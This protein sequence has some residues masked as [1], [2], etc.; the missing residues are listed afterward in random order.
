MFVDDHS[1]ISSFLIGSLCTYIHAI[2]TKWYLRMFVKWSWTLI[3]F[4]TQFFTYI[5][6][7][8]VLFQLN[9]FRLYLCSCFTRRDLFVWLW[10]DD[11]HT[12]ILLIV[13][14]YWDF[15]GYF[16]SVCIIVVRMVLA[17]LKEVNT[18]YICG[19]IIT[20]RIQLW[21]P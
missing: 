21:D 11:Y 7:F 9:Y 1:L 15:F 14:F 2:E 3:Q 5:G 13:F 17:V 18:L 20:L 10:N 6:L 4:I 16:F 8:V 12:S 19:L